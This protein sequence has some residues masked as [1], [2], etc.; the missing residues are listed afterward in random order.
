MRFVYWSI[1]A[2]LTAIACHAAF[3]LIVPAYSL[4]RTIA[5]IER[6]SGSNRFFILTEDE[7]QRL[8]PGYPRHSVTGVCAF[9]VSQSNVTLAANVPEGFWTLTIYSSRGDV[10]YSANNAQTGT[11]SFTVSLSLAPD[12]IEMLKQA[13]AKEPVDA[14]TGWTVSSPA[15]NG[16]AVLWYPVAEPAQRT[17]IIRE[18]S[19]TV[20][21]PSA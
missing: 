18:M 17:G 19:K 21:Q 7:Q 2:L 3:I 11:N 14:D 16:L 10:I 12:L 8:A 13:T 5:R 15:P 9:D 6:G 20:C 1:A 4:D